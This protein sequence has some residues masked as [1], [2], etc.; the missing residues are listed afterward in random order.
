MLSLSWWLMPSPIP[1]T[2]L[3]KTQ[4]GAQDTW[5]RLGML[6][7]AP[8]QLMPR[9]LDSSDPNPCWLSA[10]T[11]I[12]ALHL[13]TLNSLNTQHSPKC[14]QT[15]TCQHRIPIKLPSLERFG[16]QSKVW[17]RKGFGLILLTPSDEGGQGKETPGL[18]CSQIHM[19]PSAPDL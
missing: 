15:N 17:A 4:K 5:I 11:R 10:S 6:V 9:V 18:L 16:A 19:Q 1:S 8:A 2:S 12:L 7:K 14:T 13:S 3:Y